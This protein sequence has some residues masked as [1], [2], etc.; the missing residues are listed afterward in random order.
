[1]TKSNDII[2]KI[3]KNRKDLNAEQ[4]R[5]IIERYIH[6]A[7]QALIHGHELNTKVAMKMKVGYTIFNQ[8][9]RSYRKQFRY[10][11]RMFGYTLIPVCHDHIVKGYGY[12]YKPSKFLVDALADVADTDMIYN[13]MKQ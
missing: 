3:I 5:F 12:N 13:F 11:S 9:P 6:Y 1:M 8:I 4:I 10:S 2:R 7:C